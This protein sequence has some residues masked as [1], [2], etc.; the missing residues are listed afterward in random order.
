MSCKKLGDVLRD[1]RNNSGIGSIKEACSNLDVSNATLSNY[2]LGKA[3]PDVDYLA[4]FA[5]KTGAS[6][7]ELLQLRLASGKNEAARRLATTIK[8]EEKQEV[9]ETEI[10][11]LRAMF[12]DHVLGQLIES[13]V[14][15][16][17]K[18]LE[19]SGKKLPPHRKARYI[20]GC[21]DIFRELPEDQRSTRAPNFFKHL[22]Q[23]ITSVS[24]N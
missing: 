10:E 24:S 8:F 18:V 21:I 22:F 17:E 16:A 12:K 23:I 1:W 9:K 20:K 13:A 11:Q 6:F 7:N 19:E 5:E 15:I 14:E 4:M 3:L 2:E